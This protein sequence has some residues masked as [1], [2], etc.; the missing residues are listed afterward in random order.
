MLIKN[1]KKMKEL[2]F[3]SKKLTDVT[4]I[5][6]YVT[7]ISQLQILEIKLNNDISTS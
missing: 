5:V 3:L 7:D 4:I 1:K 6:T 2:V